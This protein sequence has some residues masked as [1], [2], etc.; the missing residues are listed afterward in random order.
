MAASA[1]ATTVGVNA[2]IKGVA[3]S[4]GATVGTDMHVK[5]VVGVGTMSTNVNLG[6][7]ATAGI[8]TRVVVTSQWT[9]ASTV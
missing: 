5:A 2:T 8:A 3:T 4:K 7:D 6:R 1:V 9:P